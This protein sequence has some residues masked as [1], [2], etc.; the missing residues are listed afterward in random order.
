M[1]YRRS[2]DEIIQQAMVSALEKAT[3]QGEKNKR[4]RKRIKNRQALKR[5]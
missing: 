5:K 4:Y 3:E 2:N 1:Y